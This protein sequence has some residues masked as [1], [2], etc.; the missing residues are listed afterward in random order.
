[1]NPAP[2]PVHHEIATLV[3]RLGL[4]LDEGRFDELRTLLTDDATAFTGGGRSDGADAVVA[5]ARRNH[6]AVPVQHA[7][8]DVLVDLDADGTS[9]A[10]RANLAVTFVAVDTLAPTRTVGSVYHFTARETPAGWRLAS[11]ATEPV[12]LVGEPL[13]VP[14]AG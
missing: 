11:V 9:A 13:P 7:I 2:F 4:C 3:H 14:A 1:M 5:Q 12:W 6:G 10:V 8:T